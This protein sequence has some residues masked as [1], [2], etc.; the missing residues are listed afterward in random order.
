M[1]QVVEALDDLTGKHYLELL[2]GDRFVD[3]CLLG[4]TTNIKHHN[5]MLDEQERLL[6]RRELF[7]N[8]LL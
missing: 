2:D 4:D 5:D 8:G 1:L 7:D 3:A 6:V